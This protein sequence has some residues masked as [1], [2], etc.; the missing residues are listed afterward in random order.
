[1]DIHKFMD[2]YKKV[3]SKSKNKGKQYGS[4]Y[5][6][7]LKTQNIEK[8]NK[9]KVFKDGK[10]KHNLYNISEGAIL[11]VELLIENTKVK[12]KTKTKGNNNV[13]L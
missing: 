3:K 1:M 11:K 7:C 12:T 13:N 9:G 10:P 4:S 5:R 6:E 2:C 8:M